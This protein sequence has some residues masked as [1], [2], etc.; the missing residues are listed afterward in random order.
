[1]EIREE[2]ETYFDGGY[3]AGLPQELRDG[4]AI[5][6]CLSC[7]EDC[8]T[9]LVKDRHTGQKL[10]AKCYNAKSV[11]LQENSVQR[12]HLTGTAAPDFVGEYRNAAC[13]CVLREYIE[14]TP[15]DEYMKKHRITE[16]IILDIALDL[17]KA[18]RELHESEP[19]IIHRDIKPQNIIIQGNGKVSLI[20][21][22]I[23]RVY[24]EEQTNDTFLSGTEDFASPEQFGFMQTDIRSDIYSFGVV[25]AWMLT[26][27]AKPIK[28]PLTK[29]EN[30]AA[31]CCAF[32]PEKRYKNDDMLLRDLSRLTRE[33]IRLVRTRAKKAAVCALLTA[34]VAAVVFMIYEKPSAQNSVSFREP[35]IEEAVRMVLGKPEGELSREELE[36]VREIYIQAD[37]AYATIDEFYSEGE[38]WYETDSRIHGPIESLEDLRRMPN[39]SIVFINAEHIRDISPLEELE[40]LEQVSLS[41]NYI[42]DITPLKDKERLWNVSLMSNPLK[43][44]GELQTWPVIRNL[45]LS[46][47]GYYD[48]SPVDTLESMDFLDIWNDSDAYRYLE[49]MRIGELHVGAA[50]QTGLECLR[51]T[52]YIGRLYLQKSDIRDISALEGR[53]DIT[54]FRMEECIVEDLSP[55][56][57]MPNL[58]TV[59]MSA[60]WQDRM[61][62]L[63]EEYGEPDFEI[64]YY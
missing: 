57:T 37:S 4:Y 64:V 42:S 3:E 18:M 46:L 51:D 2:F 1:M 10:V 24:K 38:K 28:A 19:V 61:E 33:H 31:K 20:D 8:D 47:T 26:G 39:L 36:Q 9:L 43:G 27:K 49:D 30:I 21:F 59:E 32:A 44:I 40:Y 60:S 54:F 41:D 63:I 55:L 29:L 56:F 15:L 23:S 13:Y 48:G 6:E 35:L 12:M 45:N 11:A 62:Q 25:L 17:V 16:E 53:T 50:G 58:M 34:A 14:G 7:K 52:A 5:I 22:G